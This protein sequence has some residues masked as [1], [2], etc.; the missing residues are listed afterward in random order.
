[1]QVWHSED[2]LI[3][4]V[5]EKKNCWRWFGR[6]LNQFGSYY[7]SR[8][9]RSFVALQDDIYL[10]A[11]R[12]KISQSPI[13]TTIIDGEDGEVLGMNLAAQGQSPTTHSIDNLSLRSV[14]DFETKDKIE[15]LP[16]GRKVI[17]SQSLRYSD[18][19][20]ISLEGSD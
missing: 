1:M 16:S 19:D 10:F 5:Q 12:Q 17:L 7:R 8:I 9:Y 15:V 18:S 14:G 6:N 4:I 11:L 2:L 13:P 20:S 3:W